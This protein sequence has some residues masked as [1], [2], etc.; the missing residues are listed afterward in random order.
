[1]RFF[2]SLTVGRLEKDDP[3]GSLSPNGQLSVV[4]LFIPT[5]LFL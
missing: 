4:T 5:I 1:M 2:H 3:L